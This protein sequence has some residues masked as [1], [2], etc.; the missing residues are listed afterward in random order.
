MDTGVSPSDSAAMR[1]LEDLW[2]AKLQCARQRYFKAAAEFHRCV[3]EKGSLS[4]TSDEFADV[5][6]AEA[7]A[8]AE[9]CRVLATVTELSSTGKLPSDDRANVAI[10][11][12][13]VV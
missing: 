10:M 13:R 4:R 5:R 1:E 6:R 9:Y 3:L 8:F 11:P 7:E 12:R 2:D